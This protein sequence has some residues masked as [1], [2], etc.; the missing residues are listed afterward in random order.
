MMG[1]FE[2]WEKCL[3]WRYALRFINVYIL[4]KAMRLNG[5]MKVCGFL[6]SR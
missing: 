6:K 2:V 5:C 3:G 1:K 4:F